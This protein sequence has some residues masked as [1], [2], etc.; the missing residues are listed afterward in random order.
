MGSEKKKSGEKIQKFE[1]WY[2]P[3]FQFWGVGRIQHLQQVKK[4]EN[5]PVQNRNLGLNQ[6]PKNKKN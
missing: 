3:S 6:R 4:Q 1:E 5:N 2:E